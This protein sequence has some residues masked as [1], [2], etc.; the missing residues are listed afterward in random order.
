MYF[1]F[2]NYYLSLLKKNNV[3]NFFLIFGINIF[4]L[5]VTVFLF[6]DF[7]DLKKC[8]NFCVFLNKIQLFFVYGNYK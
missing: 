3:F 8:S 4:F 1:I 2:K 7:H 6:I 5:K